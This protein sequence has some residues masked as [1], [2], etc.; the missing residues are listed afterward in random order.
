MEWLTGSEVNE[1]P[2]NFE[3]WLRLLTRQE[4]DIKA[5]GWAR[6]VAA[7]VA[8]RLFDCTLGFD[9]LRPAIRVAPQARLARTMVCTMECM[10]VGWLAKR[11]LSPASK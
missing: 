7:V 10:A 4:F 5:M 6:V 2:S 1:K 11:R 3:R 9:L 8:E